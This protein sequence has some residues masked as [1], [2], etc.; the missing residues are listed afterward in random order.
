MSAEH[1]LV[2]DDDPAA[3]RL[4]SRILQAVG[5]E[6]LQAATVEQARRRMAEA[7]VALVLCDINL[8][9]RSGLELLAELAASSPA[10]ATVMVTGRDDPELADETI[11]LGAYGY[12]TK[13]FTASAL[14]IEVANALHRRRLELDRRDHELELERLVEERTWQLRRAHEEVLLR[15]GRALEAYDGATGAHVERVASLAWALALQLGLTQEAAELIRRAAPLHDIG[16]LA[17]PEQ[18]RLKPGRLS[19]A[20]RELMQTHAAVGHELLA[21]SGNDLL[22]LAATIAW[23]HHERCDGSGYPR[24]ITGEEIPLEGRIVAVADVFDALTSD[25][26]YRSAL[27]FAAAWNYLDGDERHSFDAEVLDALGEMLAPVVGVA[28]PA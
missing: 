25:R 18:I 20:E 9:G 28:V 11:R 24:G 1:I 19:A 13:P 22:E 6:C 26:P 4:V 14:R 12:L 21:G 5:H 7:E 27:G 3:R 8:P 15:F 17:I 10:I 2:L 23:T 16:K